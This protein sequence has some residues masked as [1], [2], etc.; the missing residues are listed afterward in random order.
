MKF[1]KADYAEEFNWEQKCSKCDKEMTLRHGRYGPF[2]GCSAYPECKGIVNIPKK[3][4]VFIP[5]EDMPQCPAIGCEGRLA[6]RK[7]RF[8]KTFYSCSTFPECNV[9]VNDFD[10][11]AEKY[12]NHPR[13][14][15]EKKVRK[16]AGA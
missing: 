5:E 1:D 8:G 11:L 3:G 6:A 9:I 14:A 10:Q 15:Y 13:T 2:L 7:S 12:P 16:K 4:E